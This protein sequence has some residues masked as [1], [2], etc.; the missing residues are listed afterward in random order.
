MK[1]FDYFGVMIDCSR[2]A[3]PSVSGLKHF[4]DI[5][6]KMGYNC[7][8]L[9]TED[10]YTVENE[11]YFGYKRGRYTDAELQELDRY[12][13][14]VGIELIPCVQTLAHLNQIFRWRDYQP[15]CDIDDILLIDDERTMT[16]IRNMFGS[17]AKNFTSRKIHIGMDEAHH[18]G[19]GKYLDRHGLKNRFELILSH[20][21]RVCEL[22]KEYGFEPMMWE[23]MFF[24]L[25]NN[26]GFYSDK[27]VDFPEEVLRKVPDNCTMVYWDYYTTD[28][29]VYD[30][31][32]QSSKRLSDKVWF[33]GGAWV[34]GSMTP[35]NRYSMIRNEMALKYCKKHDV[36]NVILTM[37]GDNGGECPYMDG[38]AA[39]MHAAAQ[40]E[41]MTEAEMKAKFFEA[42]GESYDAFVG[43]DLPSFSRDPQD[44]PAMGRHERLTLYDDLL[45]GICSRITS[46]DGSVYPGYAKQL[47]QWAAESPAHGYLFET[48]ACLCDILAIKF[49]LPT[50]IRA[51]YAAGDKDGLRQIAEE[52]CPE[53]VR[54]LEAYYRAF[55]T[56]W[57]TVNKTYGFEVQDI[58]LGGLIRRTENCR[59]MLLD[60]CDGRIDRIEE[61]EEGILSVKGCAVHPWANTVSA[62]IL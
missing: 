57:Y 42:T 31:M 21:N 40:A 38:L 55:R 19:L 10:T 53:L 59:A 43:L 5:L 9:Y 23:D 47:H 60:Y 4:F 15:V 13:A 33:A 49:H 30:A 11:P 56:Q 39:L 28:E 32:F 26:G 61:L 46:A 48:Q 36:R 52:V 14:S 27:P 2:N 20:L 58:R 8:M 44:E 18:V 34:W 51:L 45:L 50:K 6:S 37:W 54:R 25:M 7:A 22:A 41:D 1:N 16:L 29:K 62:N 12:A 17:L 3:V 24:R 35:A